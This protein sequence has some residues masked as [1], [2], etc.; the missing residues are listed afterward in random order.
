MPYYS[1]Q[2]TDSELDPLAYSGR[3]NDADW[4]RSM[5]RSRSRNT[6]V[7]HM[8]NGRLAAHKTSQQGSQS[9]GEDYEVPESELEGDEEDEDK[10]VDLL[11]PQDMPFQSVG[12]PTLRR[13]T[14][15]KHPRPPPNGFTPITKTV[16]PRKPLDVSVVL[17]ST[18]QRQDYKQFRSD[19]LEEWEEQET[20]VDPIVTSD[21][22]PN[23]KR[24]KHEYPV[25]TLPP[26]LDSKRPFPDAGTSLNPAPKKR[27]RPLGW[28]PGSGPYS[29]KT[30]KEKK[31]LATGE[32]K[33]RG[34]P[35]RQRTPPPRHIYLRSEISKFNLFI[36]EWEGCPA[37]LQNLDTLRRHITIVHGKI[38]T[39]R[40]DQAEISTMICKWGTCLIKNPN[41]VLHDREAFIKHIERHMSTQAWYMG[42]GPKN[43]SHEIDYSKVG[44]IP[45]RGDAD[46]LPSYLFDQETGEQVTP[47]IK[48]QEFENE[49]ERKERA[50]KLERTRIQMI[51]NAPDH[52]RYTE[53]QAIEVQKELR[54]EK[55]RKHMYNKYYEAVVD[56]PA[57]LE[58][59]KRKGAGASSQNPAASGE[60]GTDAQADGLKALVGGPIYG[61]EW[62]GNLVGL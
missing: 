20:D 42:D 41:L 58:R 6:G 47:S 37:K 43:N 57:E 22:L 44:I 10:Q 62:K 29:T 36:C 56:R 53:A 4:D 17:N 31:L 33:R 40:K 32:A 60:T 21:L 35:P 1:N 24:R 52:P 19:E 49:K 50:M 7:M 55:E 59:L 15:I 34:R 14:A 28:R 26:P 27:G 46:P 25:P 54:K 18:P 45:T 12:T 9:G 16:S 38:K 23:P 2:E 13:E 61:P 30:P 39:H 48:D 51:E 11:P 5:S 3:S 8:V